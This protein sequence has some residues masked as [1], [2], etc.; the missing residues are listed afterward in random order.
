MTD[1]VELERRRKLL[2]SPV[3]VRVQRIAEL[4]GSKTYG[5]IEEEHANEIVVLG[6]SVVSDLLDGFMLACT[7]LDDIAKA[8]RERKEPR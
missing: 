6:T 8:A 5:N 4:W 2:S 3:G 1:A 7:A